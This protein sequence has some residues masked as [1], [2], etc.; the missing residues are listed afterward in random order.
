MKGRHGS[1]AAPLIAHVVH[2]FRIGGLENGVVNLINR[3][4]PERAR[5]AIVA[6]TTWDADFTR[7]VRNP[8]VS[9]HA[10]GRRA[11]QDLGMLLR[12]W[13][14]FRRMRPAIVHTRNLG[15][16]EAQLP[17]AL[18]GVR[19]RVHGEHG[20]DVHDQWGN[21]K[22]LLWRQAFRP[23][24]GRYIALS[25]ELADY[26]TGP[27]GVPARRVRRIC[28]GVDLERFRPGHGR[29]ETREA[30]GFGSEEVVIGTVGRLEAIKDPLNLADAFIR[31]AGPAGRRAPRARLL[32]VGGGSLMDAVR[33]RLDAAGV[34]DRVVLAG[35]RDDVPELLRAMDVFVL[36]SKAEG[37]SNTILE[38]MATGLPLVATRVGGNA[39]LVT[40]GETGFLVPREDSSALA[41]AIVRYLDDLSLRRAHGAAARRRAEQEFSMEA[42]VDGYLAV[43]DELLSRS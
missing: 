2:A 28:N 41:D 23:F 25:G 27:V 6:L 9:Y 39:E 13:R 4:P 30:L 17:A 33:E 20:W 10:V 43:Y 7:R 32:M 35:S 12:L 26:Q 16:L 37:I 5:H 38:A 11:G 34:T 24:V 22:Y 42:M 1:A 3:I 29:K 36:P 40:E 21:R 19:G 8:E 18:A 31:L 15:T 14:L